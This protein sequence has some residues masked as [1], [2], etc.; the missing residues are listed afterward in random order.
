L[1]VRSSAFTI[2]LS[3]VLDENVGSVPADSTG[4]VVRLFPDEEVVVE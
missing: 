3:G 4:P 2:N 1:A